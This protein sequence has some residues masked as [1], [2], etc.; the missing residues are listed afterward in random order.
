MT[1]PLELNLLS[2]NKIFNVS[3]QLILTPYKFTNNC[4]FQKGDATIIKHVVNASRQLEK[5]QECYDA[6]A[7]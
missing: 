3:S 1:F 6:T 5:L 7:E 2:T 4:R